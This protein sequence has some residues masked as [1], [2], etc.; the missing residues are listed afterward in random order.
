M[1]GQVT[2][3]CPPAQF[4][5]V[6]NK[7]A[8]PQAGWSLA[9]LQFPFPWRDH[10]GGARRSCS[11]WPTLVSRI[12]RHLNQENGSLGT[13]SAG[14]KDLTSVRNWDSMKPLF[15]SCP[16]VPCDPLCGPSFSDS[17]SFLHPHNLSWHVVAALAS[18][19]SPAFQP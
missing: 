18:L 6:I 1:S 2:A 12:R 3:V 15:P 7:T 10:R 9:S 11:V 17:S 5:R 16:C 13:H 4:Q 8:L 19:A 14:L